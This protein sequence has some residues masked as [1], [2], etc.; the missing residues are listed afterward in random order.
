[1]DGELAGS[2]DRL[3]SQLSPPSCFVILAE[4][5]TCGDLSGRALAPG[6]RQPHLSAAPP[7]KRALPVERKHVNYLLVSPCLRLQHPIRHVLDMTS[8]DGDEFAFT[9]FKHLAQM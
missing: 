2:H 4:G 9:L 8:A 3:P 7:S 5:L 1:V 6:R